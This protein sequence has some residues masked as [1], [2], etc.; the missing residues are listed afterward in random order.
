MSTEL[1]KNEISRFLASKTPEV[2]CIKG[3]WGVGKTFSWRRYLQEASQRTAGIGLERY[4]YVSLFGVNS[5]DEVKYAIFEGTVKKD[6]VHQKASLDTLKSTVESAEGFGRKYAWLA[7]LIPGAKSY[8]SGAAPAFFL[9]VRNQIVCIDDLE[10]KGSKLESADV[11]GL[12]S[13]LKEE[14]GCKVVLLLNDEALASPDRQKFEAYLEKVVDVSLTFAPTAQECVSVALPDADTDSQLIRDRCSSLGIRNIRV[15]KKIE[16]LVR[17][18]KPLLQ[19]DA[20]VFDRATSSLALIGWSYYQ[21]DEA[22]TLDY[23]IH[24]RPKSLFGLK[25]SQD[26]PEKETAWNALLD[27]YGYMSTDEFDLVLIDGVRNGYFDPEKVE[28]HAKE[29][30]EKILA[31]RAE[32]SFEEAWR[33]YHDSFDNNQDEVLDGIYSSFMKNYNHI[34]PLNLNGTVSL[35]RELGRDAQASEMIKFYV[36]NRDES[37]K[38]FDLEEYAFGSDITDPEIV[39]AFNA[40][41][42]TISEERDLPALLL[43]LKDGWDGDALAALAT[44]PVDEYYRILKESSGQN[45]RRIIAGALQFEGVVNA[46]P[47]MKEISKRTKEAL[48]RIGEESDVNARR[49]TKFG[50]HVKKPDLEI[51][52]E[53]APE[54]SGAE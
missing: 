23:L 13:F 17:T 34:S 41:L 24:K 53:A 38:F 47:A 31:A 7:N 6:Q 2:L 8:L 35:F 26:T 14:R 21:P 54:A 25:K 22:P 27:A 3:K 29:I 43:R 30:R 48:T 18:I 52:S 42:A 1:V 39:D 5:L 46:S 10:R 49:V 4:A 33:K 20:E 19:E 28:L 40:K 50:V 45:L 44:M 16:R 9:T 11:L 51:Q 12:T 36:A 15:I 37:R 32:G